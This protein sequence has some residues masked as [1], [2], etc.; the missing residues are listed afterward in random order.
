MGE[1]DEFVEI[2]KVLFNEISRAHSRS[3]TSWDTILNRCETG[4]TSIMDILAKNTEM[5]KAAWAER[6][7]RLDVQVDS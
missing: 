7:A 4:T 5:T 2:V 6:P 1:M 3:F